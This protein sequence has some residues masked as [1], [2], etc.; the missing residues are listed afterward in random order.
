MTTGQS[1]RAERRTART[2]ERTHEGPGQA[3]SGH[4]RR[5]QSPEVTAAAETD[6]AAVEAFEPEWGVVEL[7]FE[8][9]RDVARTVSWVAEEASVERSAYLASALRYECRRATERDEPRVAFS[10]TYHDGGWRT[11]L[12]DLADEETPYFT[13][14]RRAHLEEFGDLIEGL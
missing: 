8:M 6:R 12:S 1:S 13:D 7:V 9:D 5:R 14:R 3:G 10:V 11:W 2:V 4:P